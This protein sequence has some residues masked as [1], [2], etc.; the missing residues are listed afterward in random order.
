VNQAMLDMLNDKRDL[1]R[2]ICQ[3]LNE[4]QSQTG[5]ALSNISFSCAPETGIDP[6]PVLGVDLEFTL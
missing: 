1:E 6:G 4:F 5:L 2:K 3:L